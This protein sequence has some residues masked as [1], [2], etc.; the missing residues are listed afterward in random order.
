[1]VTRSA[2]LFCGYGP[3]SDLLARGQGTACAAVRDDPVKLSRLVKTL[4]ERLRR[5]DGIGDLEGLCRELEL[6]T[7]SDA[8]GSPAS[9]TRKQGPGKTLPIDPRPNLN[10]WLTL[11]SEVVSVRP[12]P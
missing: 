12:Y 10:G 5:G 6:E 1:M 4:K 7:V 2:D 11:I 3:A 9:A 8:G